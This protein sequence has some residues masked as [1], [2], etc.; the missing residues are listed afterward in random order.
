MSETDN[1]TR[2]PAVAC[3]FCGSS[4]VSE[5]FAE[6]LFHYGPEPVTLSATV[7]VTECASCGEAYTCG[8]AEI[9]RQ[10]AVDRHVASPKDGE[11][12]VVG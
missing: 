2:P 6:Q 8:D 10:A 3:D 9:A 11:E 7:R 5:R 1:E 12:A 4:Q